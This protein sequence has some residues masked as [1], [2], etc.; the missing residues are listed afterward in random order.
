MKQSSAWKKLGKPVVVV[1]F[2]GV[3]MDY[4]KGFRGVD[5]FDEAV[6]GAGEALQELQ[7]ANWHIVI[8]TTRFASPALVE[9]LKDKK[10]PYNA[11]NS[12]DHNPPNTSHKPIAT[13]YL[14]DRAWPWGGKQYTKETW[15]QI[16]K[17]LKK[18]QKEM[19]AFA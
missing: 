3:I 16:V 10:I 18:M 5:V 6:D 9:W 7:D 8:F 13:V 1:D 17:D 12:T 2:D 14:D 4:T 15:Q 19:S 11:L